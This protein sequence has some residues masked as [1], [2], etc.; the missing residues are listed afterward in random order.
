MQKRREPGGRSGQQWGMGRWEQLRDRQ[1]LG[2]VSRG[3]EAA[4]RALYDVHAPRLA[5]RLAKRGAAPDEIEEVLQEVF[6]TAWRSAA[7]YRAD[8]D[9]GAWLWGIATRK[10]AMAVRSAV[11]RR[12]VDAPPASATSSEEDWIVAIDAVDRLE[13][14]DPELRATLE[15]VAVKG[16][17]VADAASRLGVPEGTV[18]SR[19]HRLRRSIEEA[20]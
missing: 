5:A 14:L 20:T 9:V 16:L 1:R 7:S 4:L 19:M 8:G 3:D 18:K 13:R 17:S 12:T 2:A 10:Y 11:R 6:V 15:A